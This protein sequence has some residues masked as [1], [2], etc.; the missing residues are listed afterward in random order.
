MWFYV[1]VVF[2]S[3]VVLMNFI[4]SLEDAYMFLGEAQ[5]F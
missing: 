1:E 4:V 2:A 5:D 3:S